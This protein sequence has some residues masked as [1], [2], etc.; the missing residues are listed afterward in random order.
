[1]LTP[2]QRNVLPQ[3]VEPRRLVNQGVTLV[4]E[5][6]PDLCGR[7]TTAVFNTEERGRKVVHVNASTTIQIACHRCLEPMLLPLACDTVLGIVWSEDQAKSLPR[8]LEP[9]IVEEEAGDIAAL[10][11]YELLLVLPFV[12]YHPEDQCSATPSYSTHEEIEE[13][14]PVDNPFSILEQLR[15]SGSDN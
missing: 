9:W 11:E 6:A 8:D 1:M 2:P 10:V 4:G 7:L 13:S 3:V 14:T 5:V 12:I 15:S